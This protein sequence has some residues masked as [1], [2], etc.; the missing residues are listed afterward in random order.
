MGKVIAKSNCNELR[1]PKEIRE[2]Y[3]AELFKLNAS[4]R[5]EQD[6]TTINSMIHS[7]QLS[8]DNYLKSY[9]IDDMYSVCMCHF[10]CGLYDAIDLV[11]TQR[12]WTKDVRFI[13][14]TCC[15]DA[16]AHYDNKLRLALLCLDFNKNIPEDKCKMQPRR[17]ALDVYF[18]PKSVRL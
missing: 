8:L 14:T 5:Y 2:A 16:M 12:P 10:Y 7:L 3:G 15:I 4:K 18:K 11:I 6:I 1:D 17:I 9:T 13:E